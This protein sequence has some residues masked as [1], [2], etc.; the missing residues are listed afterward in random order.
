MTSRNTRH[1]HTG[2][3]VR[4][5]RSQKIVIV[6]LLY[7]VSLCV[8]SMISDVEV[9]ACVFV[10]T[11][12]AVYCSLRRKS[13]SPPGRR[14]GADHG[15]YCLHPPTNILKK[16]ASVK[17]AFSLVSSIRGLSRDQSA[18]GL[19][20]LSLHCPVFPLNNAERPENVRNHASWKRNAAERC[21]R[22][23]DASRQQPH[24]L[25]YHSRPV[26]G[27]FEHCNAPAWPLLG[28]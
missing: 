22:Y 19:P 14:G 11:N 15:L 16:A 26:K 28:V 3:T 8:F 18:K 10:M 12:P 1:F 27:V 25:M 17:R 13:S 5:C 21:L 9:S 6:V 23:I 2:Y 20:Q 4:L 7:F 24:W